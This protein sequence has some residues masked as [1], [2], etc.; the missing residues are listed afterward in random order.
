ML[1]MLKADGGRAPSVRKVGR[2]AV[3]L[4]ELTGSYNT[5]DNSIT[6]PKPTREI[7]VSITDQVLKV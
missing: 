2:P 3:V 1:S 6:K 4:P 7:K 5:S